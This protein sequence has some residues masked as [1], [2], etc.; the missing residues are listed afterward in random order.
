ML[1]DLQK[2]SND[3]AQLLAKLTESQIIT[4]NT[5][6]GFDVR[7]RKVEGIVEKEIYLTNAQLREVSRQV[8]DRV[9]AI[10]KEK[11]YNYKL[12]S[13][14]LFQAIYRSINGQYNVPSY[15]ELPRAY[16]TD[17]IDA[18]KSWQV[19]AIIEERISAA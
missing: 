18:I 15:R 16:F 6:A 12:S 8:K 1:M 10:R 13:K 17:I 2:N 14:I 3:I 19:T 9:S 5:L 11:G 7:L 4:N